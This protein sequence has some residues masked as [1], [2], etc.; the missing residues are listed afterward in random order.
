LDR[1]GGTVRAF[2]TKTTPMPSSPTPTLV[3]SPATARVA[4][5]PVRMSGSE[6]GILALL[7]LIWGG[8]FLFIKIA[9]REI[10]TLSIVL[11]RV[12]MAS[13]FLYGIARWRGTN[14]AVG[15][16]LWGVFALLGLFN[17]IV[18]FSLITWGETRIP[19]GL[20][21]ILNATTPLFSII[22]T[23]FFLH[24]ERLSWGK[25][26]G[27]GFGIVGVAVIVGPDALG[28]LFDNV[29]A[30]VAILGAACSYAISAIIAKKMLKLVSPIATATGQVA[31]AAVMLAPIAL[32]VDR[33]WS[34]P[35]PS[36]VAI[37]SVVALAALC[38]SFAY[39]LYF[40]LLAGAGATNALLVTFLIPASAILLGALFENESLHWWNFAG[41]ALI[42]VG[43]AAIDGRAWEAWKRRGARREPPIE[44]AFEQSA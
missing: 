32:F 27:V 33:P 20:A 4:A 42:G 35:A 15:W 26:I 19:L 1:G 29:V 11:G 21:A 34:L 9:G 14:L 3:S 28:G 31:T 40:R 44:P 5:A 2:S 10:P 37:W 8:S 13:L 23:H 41:L 24:D 36:A 38:T 30:Q 39:V 6:W 43:L 17:N 18:P 12:S 22:L 7:S 16:R 25:A